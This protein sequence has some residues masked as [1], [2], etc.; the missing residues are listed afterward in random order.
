MN[1][2]FL[3]ITKT[4]LLWYPHIGQHNGAWGIATAL[5]CVTKIVD[6]YHHLLFT[7]YYDTTATDNFTFL[8]I[9][10][11]VLCAINVI[12]ETMEN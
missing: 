3:C 6:N 5:W 7:Y 4:H 11:P 10:V 9:K 8:T 1:C 12:G 2:N